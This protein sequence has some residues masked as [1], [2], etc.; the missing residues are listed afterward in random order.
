M[1]STQSPCDAIRDML[2]AQGAVASGIAEAAPIPDADFAPFEA[3]LADGCHASMTYMENYRDLRRDPRTLLPGARSLIVAAFSYYHADHTE[4][5]LER[6]AAY[7]HGDDYHEV[8]RA[9][10]DIVARAIKETWGAETRVCVDTAPLP[11]RYWA[12][13]AGIGFIGRNGMLIT[14]AAGSY[15]FIATII[16][17]LP[18]PPSA[19]STATC[20]SCN[21]C[22][23][24]CPT[25]AITYPQ[26]KAKSES[27]APQK[28]QSQAPQSQALQGESQSQAQSESLPP[29]LQEEHRADAQRAEVPP[30][31][32]SQAAQAQSQS[33]AAQA[34][35]A[36][37]DRPIQRIDARRCLSCLTI[38]HRG[39]F[40]P[41]TD[42]H[43][44]LYGCD[45]CQRVCPHNRNLPD[46]TISEFHPRPA[47]RTLTPAAIAALT[48]ADFSTIFRHSAIK[49]TKLQGLQRNLQAIHD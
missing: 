35:E 22:L 40:P 23:Q 30:S 33:Q 13:R 34:Q 16:T 18:L 27:Q 7:A 28:A 37:P 10:L 29:K 44:R 47:L 32:P 39:D 36:A 4:G 42:L 20:L 6:I 46:T 11:E 48:P 1:N 38:E 12:V 25:Q 21:R 9:R 45:L 14:P 15:I 19:P 5:N 31:L 43:G 17:T 2:A 26:K 41:G 24:A 8:L 49:R 3:W